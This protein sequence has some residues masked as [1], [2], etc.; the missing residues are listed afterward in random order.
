M[1]RHLL[2][3]CLPAVSMNCFRRV[4][5]TGTHLPATRFTTGVSGCHAE[6]TLTPAN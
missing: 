6:V 3:P 1:G 2:A 4:F 5:H